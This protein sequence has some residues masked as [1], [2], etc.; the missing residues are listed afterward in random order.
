MWGVGVEQVVDRPGQGDEPRRAGEGQQDGKQK[1]EGGL[2]LCLPPPPGGLG[3]G[4]GG[5][6]DRG[7]SD[8]QGEGKI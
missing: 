6:Q 1:G 4:E 5:D 7:Q 2:A 8:V 3:P